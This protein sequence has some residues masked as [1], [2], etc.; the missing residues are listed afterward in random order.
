MEVPV[1]RDTRASAPI[2]HGPLCFPPPTAL[3]QLTIPCHPLKSHK[4]VSSATQLHKLH[5]GAEQ[6]IKC[7]F[8]PAPLADPLSPFQQ[9]LVAESLNRLPQIYIVPL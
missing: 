1:N 5:N 3:D 6:C 9:P 2:A 7:W 8:P 4:Q